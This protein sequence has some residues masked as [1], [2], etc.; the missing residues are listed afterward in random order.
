M[1][2]HLLNLRNVTMWVLNLST[3]KAGIA[4]KTPSYILQWST[5]T[6]YV[7]LKIKYVNILYMQ[8]PP[9]WRF[10]NGQLYILV[11][12]LR[13]AETNT[14]YIMHYLLSGRLDVNCLFSRNKNIAAWCIMNN[15]FI[16]VN[17]DCS[18]HQH[19]CGQSK[20]MITMLGSSANSSPNPMEN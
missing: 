7:T 4:K 11:V 17:S 19:S 10:W 13:T 16:H 6:L 18:K 8:I 12:W 15:T 20:N 1:F 9:E 14:K 5:S 2:A 3:R